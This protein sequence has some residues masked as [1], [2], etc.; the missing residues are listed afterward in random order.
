MDQ[1]K[2]KKEPRIG[3]SRIRAPLSTSRHIFRSKKLKNLK[4]ARKWQT[5]KPTKNR[6]NPKK[7]IGKMGDGIQDRNFPRKNPKCRNKYRELDQK[8]RSFYRQDQKWGGHGGGTPPTSRG[9]K[10]R[11]VKWLRLNREEGIRKRWPFAT[12]RKSNRKK[13][14]QNPEKQQ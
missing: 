1:K 13:S 8:C 11:L 12:K 3:K 5:K 2:K 6:K 14:T 4:D 7:N 10:C 9:V